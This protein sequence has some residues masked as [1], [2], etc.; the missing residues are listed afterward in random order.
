MT[1]AFPAPLSAFARH[2]DQEIAETE[3]GA[4]GSRAFTE[5]R[6]PVWKLR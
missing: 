4:E 3:D 1:A 5:K 2:L 6:R